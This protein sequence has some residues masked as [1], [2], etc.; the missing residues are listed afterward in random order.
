VGSVY[1]GQPQNGSDHLFVLS[2]FEYIKE[3]KKDFHI[4]N[5]TK[6]EI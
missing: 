6:L 4:E 5:T 2:D 1:L 3:N